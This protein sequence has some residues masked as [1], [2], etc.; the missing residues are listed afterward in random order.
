MPKEID[1]SLII[2]GQFDATLARHIARGMNKAIG[3]GRAVKA[4]KGFIVKGRELTDAEYNKLW[5]WWDGYV[6]AANKFYKGKW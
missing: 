3:G 6:Y 4:V 5:D 1:R 2:M